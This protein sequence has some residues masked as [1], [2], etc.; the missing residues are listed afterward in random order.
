MRRT[1]VYLVAAL[2]VAIAASGTPAGKPPAA[3]AQDAT[4]VVTSSADT[5]A[6]SGAICPHPDLCTLRRAIE[7]ANAD[8]GAAPYIIGFDPEVFPP[9]SPTAIAVGNE[10]LPHVTRDGV[11]I[12][13]SGAGVLLESAATSLT[14]T[15]NGLTVTGDGF[16]VLGMQLRG[17][18]GSC[19][20]VTGE[21]AAIGGPEVGDG[22]TVGGC[23][24][25]IAIGGADA[26]IQGNTVGFTPAGEADPVETGIV[27]AAADAMVGGPASHPGA[28]NTI[29]FAGVAVFVGSGAAQAFSGTLI[30]NNRFGRG[31]S[32]E[33]APVGT[34][35]VLAQPS[36]GSVVTGNQISFAETGI[37]VQPDAGSV[38]AV[39]NRLGGNTFDSIA[40]LAIDLASDGVR[41][42]NDDGDA[43]TG[44]N[45]MLNHP[46]ITR[47]T[48][49]RLTGIACAG[50]SVQV[51]RADHR[52][53]GL[54]DYGSVPL[55]NG[56]LTADQQGIF[57]L[58][59]PAAAP[60]D[61][62]VAV[63]TDPDGNSSEFGPP[64]RVGAGA[65]LCGNVQLQAGWNHVGYFGPEPVALSNVF[66]PVPSGAVTAIYR[67]IDGTST[68]EA[69]F[70]EGS[71][72]RTLHT[73]QP[74]EAYWFYATAP[75]TLP[76]GFSLSFPLPVQL[77][78]GWNDFA[79]IGATAEAP[80]ALASVGV[81]R[82]LYQYEA[83]SGRWLRYG[84]ASVP[85]WAR[86]FSN[87]ESCGVYQVRVQ[88]AVTLVP[89]QP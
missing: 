76:G 89:L 71:A 1:A 66:A 53:G 16:T 63:A 60:G 10:A 9:D 79:Y 8:D 11:I 78:A 15:Q 34:A 24:A 46:L 73:V 72:G 19:L 45:T 7:A 75:V 39:R 58:D 2:A 31:P 38:A 84:D 35:V 37:A 12:D 30:E 14:T 70:A 28:R 32:S 47:A 40:G 6:S 77:K 25:G 64:S 86:E 69:W 5:G 61:W 57:A 80:D 27:I 42:P 56:L 44:P 67:L 17:F 65:V 48:Q 21:A 22:N 20:A 68:F 52:A 55:A 3:R 43:D 51:Y 85:A 59:N 83:V 26:R 49:A 41:N 62:L 13:A 81:F 54:L 74:G 29:G 18:S 33:P 23:T 36:N 87:V 88:T 82:D 4:I 50:C